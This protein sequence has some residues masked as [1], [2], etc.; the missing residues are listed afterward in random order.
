MP[1]MTLHLLTR[2]AKDRSFGYTSPE[3]SH[4]PA[5]QRYRSFGYV[6][7]DET[8]NVVIGFRPC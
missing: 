4:F 7:L 8:H 3:E 2:A 1:S 6:P 5:R